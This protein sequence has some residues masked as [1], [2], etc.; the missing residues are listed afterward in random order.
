[1]I[2]I[3]IHQGG[4]SAESAETPENREAAV[5]AAETLNSETDMLLRSA[6]PPTTAIG[7]ISKENYLINPSLD[8]VVEGDWNEQDFIWDR[9][10]STKVLGFSPQGLYKYEARS[11]NPDHPDTGLALSEKTVTVGKSVFEKLGLTSV[12]GNNVEVIEELAFFNNKLT[13][14]NSKFSE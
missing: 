9:D 11:K 4:G 10:D 8:I 14:I 3:L 13:D 5:P 1:M 7:M 2:P 12:T 6:V